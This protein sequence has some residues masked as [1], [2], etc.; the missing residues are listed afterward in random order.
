MKSLW[1]HLEALESPVVYCHNDINPQNIIYSEERGKVIEERKG[2]LL[3]NLKELC[4]VMRLL[5][6]HLPFVCK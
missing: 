4:L 2:I 3:K 6:T 5:T 1:N